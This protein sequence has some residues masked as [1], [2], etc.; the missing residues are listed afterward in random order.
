MFY[1]T[2]C[3]GHVDQRGFVEVNKRIVVNLEYICAYSPE[4]PEES[5]RL[6]MA[7]GREIIIRESYADFSLA[8]LSKIG[9]KPNAW[10]EDKALAPIDENGEEL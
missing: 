8:N 7:N 5:T 1:S 2:Y 9:P 3:L 10:K 6:F 4:K